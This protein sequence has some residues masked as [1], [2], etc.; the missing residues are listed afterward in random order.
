MHVVTSEP[1]LGYSFVAASV[2]GAL[3][4]HRATAATSRPCWRHKPKK[5]LHIQ[6]PKDNTDA[7]F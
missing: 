7:Q 6:P 3:Q 1:K 5:I 2:T 4:K